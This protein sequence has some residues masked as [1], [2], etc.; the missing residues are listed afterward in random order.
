MS[1]LAHPKDQESPAPPSRKLRRSLRSPGHSRLSGRSGAAL[2]V[3]FVALA[4]GIWASPIA[5]AATT[6]VNLATASSY[7]VLAGSTIT[8]TGA[9]VISG[10]IGLSPGTAVVGFPPGVQ[11]SG[12]TQVADAQAGV[13]QSDLTAAYV[14][15]AT[16]TQS[17]TVSS[18]LGGSTLVP[19][20]YRS[21]SGLSLTG[22]L[23]LNG[24]G[25]ANAVF[26]F[27]AGS[28]LIAAAA[29]QVILENGAQACNVFWQIGSS[30]TLGTTSHIIGSLMALTSITLDTGARVTGRVLARNGAVTLDGNNI[31][32]PTCAAAV[33]TTT[34]SP[35]VTTTSLTPTTTTAAVST[36]TAAVSTTT[37]AVSTTTAPARTTTTKPRSSATTTT[38][39]PTTSASTVTTIT[40]PAASPTTTTTAAPT[41]TT[42]A[43]STTTTTV[44]P[45]GP[46]ATG[47]GGTAGRP[48]SSPRT[49]LI[50][51][52][53]GLAGFFGVL[54]L[55]ERRRG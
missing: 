31:A 43:A 35:A 50:L 40:V 34:T 48:P 44:I 16:R 20:V 15:A 46:P 29:S 54:A 21:S 10:D 55:R 45:S 26:I 24:G 13:A 4:A 38:T 14:D 41:T 2:A 39:I 9:S 22:T 1:A 32:V 49:P 27:Q 5:G 12:S 6:T 33:A 7:A 17:S 52:S 25:D 51:G 19:G 36:T 28:T 11:S 37:A 3:S 53:L 42:T 18:D 23:T 8:N 30:A 47:E